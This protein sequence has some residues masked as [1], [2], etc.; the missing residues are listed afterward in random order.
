MYGTCSHGFAC[1]VQVVREVYDEWMTLTTR[2]MCRWLADAFWA[3]GGGNDAG[4]VILFAPQ[5][6]VDSIRRCNHTGVQYRMSLKCAVSKCIRPSHS[7]IVAGSN[8][9]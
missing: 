6:N 5:C 9:L 3:D 1:V 7:R 2:R 8:A 4:G